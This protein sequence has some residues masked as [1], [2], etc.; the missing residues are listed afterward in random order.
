VRFEVIEPFWGIFDTHHIGEVHLHN[1]GDCIE[2]G[3]A[4]PYELQRG[5]KYL[6]CGRIKNGHHIIL[7]T[8]MFKLANGQLLDPEG[9]PPPVDDLMQMVRTF[10]S[11]H[12]LATTLKAA[13]LI[14]TVRSVS[15][16]EESGYNSTQAEVELVHAGQIPDRFIRIHQE[17]CTKTDKPDDYR[18]APVFE[19][20]TRYLL[21]LQEGPG[22][23]YS[24]VNG[25]L[26]AWRISGS[27]IRT[28]LDMPAGGYADA[29]SIARTLPQPH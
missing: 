22:N 23:E 26:G 7:D 20:D 21:A 13:D 27:M 24:C 6:V 18:L 16:T 4:Y 14:V 1:D 10:Q 2:Y 5:D 11:K 17:H 25:F 8:E 29:V 3:S 19:A 15:T 12:D 9:N 28:L